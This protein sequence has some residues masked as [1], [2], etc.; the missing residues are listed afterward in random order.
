M[1]YHATNFSYFL[2]GLI[3]IKNAFGFKTSKYFYCGFLKI[4]NKWYS[5][6]P[7]LL[8]ILFAALGHTG[9]EGKGH[10][11]GGRAKTMASLDAREKGRVHLA[12]VCSLVTGHLVCPHGLRLELLAIWCVAEWAV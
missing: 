10:M 2:L 1:E 5:C 3:S 8:P 7:A 12:T 4:K 6:L 11:A 9:N